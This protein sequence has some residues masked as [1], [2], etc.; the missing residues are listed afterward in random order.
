MTI[1]LYQ[2]I[3][4]SITLSLIYV[5]KVSARRSCLV[6]INLALPCTSGLEISNS[7]S[8]GLENNSALTF[9]VCHKNDLVFKLLDGNKKNETSFKVKVRRYNGKY[10][11]LN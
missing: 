6:K 11:S 2:I 1:G 9:S 10:F 7:P 3:L 4:L 5:G 8:I